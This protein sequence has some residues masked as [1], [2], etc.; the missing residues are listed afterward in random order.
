MYVI[1]FFLDGTHYRLTPAYDFCPI[2]RERRNASQAVE[3]G[4]EG[5]KSTLRNAL[6]RCTVS[7]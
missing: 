7:D 3:V 6:T 4:L 5:P 2:L 1:M